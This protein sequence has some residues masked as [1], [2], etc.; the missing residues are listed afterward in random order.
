MTTSISFIFYAVNGFKKVEFHVQGDVSGYT[1]A[2]INHVI[3][4]VAVMLGCK[5]EDILLNGVR[6]S[7]SFL[8][9]LLV[10]EIYISKLLKEKDCIKLIRYNID[11]L[12]IDG[13]IIRLERPKGK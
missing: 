1:R 2:Y 8:L 5:D 9:S 6:H 10:K 3:K 7:K 4:T 12:I 13:E 11:Y